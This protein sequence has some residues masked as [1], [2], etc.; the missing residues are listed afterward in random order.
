KNLGLCVSIIEMMDTVVPSFLDPEIAVHLQKYLCSKNIDIYTGTKVEALIGDDIGSITSVKTDKCE[1]PAQLVLIAVGVR[2]NTKL[3]EDAGLE[4]GHTKAIKINEYCQTSDPDIYAGGDCVENTNLITGKPCYVPLGSIA[5]KHGRVIGDNITGGKSK[6][7]G[8]L[9]TA[10]FKVF[11]FNVGRTGLSEKECKK[12]GIPYVTAITPGPDRAHYYPTSK[13]VILKMIAN[14][15]TKKLLGVQ[16][17]G[18][19][20]VV[21]RIDVAATALH[22]GADVNNISEIDLGYA[23]PFSSAVDIISHAANVID[24]KLNNIAKSLTPMQ[25]KEKMDRGDDFILLDVRSPQELEQMKLNDPRVL[26]IPL[27]KLRSRLSEIPKDKEIVAFC[28]I[29][30]RGY[31]AQRILEGVGYNKVYFMDGGLAGWPYP[32]G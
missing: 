29:S 26:H 20:D 24:N 8:V 25:V 22:F 15:E 12:Q 7:E 5:N 17:V 16:V 4:I 2:P 10:V 13:P 6:F 23:P 19:G 31:E 30:L 28:K 18:M 11:D 21:K 1:I 32:M 9:G 3:A 27:G 14:P